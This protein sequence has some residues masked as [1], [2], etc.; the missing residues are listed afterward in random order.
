M[1][2]QLFCSFLEWILVQKTQQQQSTSTSA[3]FGQVL[4]VQWGIV[5][6]FKAKKQPNQ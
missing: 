3:D 6:I 2:K 5:F 1:T 4:L